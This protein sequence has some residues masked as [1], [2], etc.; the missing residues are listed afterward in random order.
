MESTLELFRQETWHR[1]GGGNRYLQLS[2]H[3][4]EAIAEG[5]LKPGDQLPP[6]RDLASIANVSRVTIRK[7]VSELV[8]VGLI[9]Q[10]RGA[11]SFINGPT[12]PT[13][14][15]LSSLVSFSDNLKRRGKVP[16][17]DVLERGLFVP[18]SD[19]MMALGLA[20]NQRVARVNRLRSSDDIPMAIE[21]SSLPADVLPDPSKVD[22]SLYA[23]LR[24]NDLAPVRAIQ[25]V[26]AINV[27]GE[28]AKLLGLAD[29]TAI[30]KITRTAFLQGGRPI[31]F[32]RGLYRP[33]NYDFMV[34]LRPDEVHLP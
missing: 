21:R 25:R 14:Q 23:I 12:L 34:E 18:T 6:E 31:E 13:E 16:V 33:D 10:R 19:E 11:G 32:T 1:P 15:S 5:R 17:S 20:P 27:F 3:I 30:L 29:N 4:A 8:Q 9:T 2:R 28:E 7:A 22:V 24:Q 26:S